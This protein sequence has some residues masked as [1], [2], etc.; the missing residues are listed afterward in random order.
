MDGCGLVAYD[1]A[2]VRSDIVAAETGEDETD[3]HLAIADVWDPDRSI[4]PFNGL[5]RSNL[6]G[7]ERIAS[8][9]SYGHIGILE[10]RTGNPTP[11][12]LWETEL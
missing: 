7:R 6:D 11:G 4:S 8:Y 9:Q 3:G 10:H 5:D 2:R 1:H 12:L